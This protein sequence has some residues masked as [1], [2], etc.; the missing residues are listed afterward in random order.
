MDYVRK[1]TVPNTSILGL[2]LVAVMLI[3]LGGCKKKIGP[4]DD[5]LGYGKV[6]DSYVESAKAFNDAIVAYSEDPTLA[7]CQKMKSAGADYLEEAR[8]CKAL[9]QILKKEAEEHWAN[10]NDVDCSVYAED[11]Y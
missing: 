6:C 8:K 9:S 7:S 11:N 1:S 2:A 5:G 3:T 10:W 4:L